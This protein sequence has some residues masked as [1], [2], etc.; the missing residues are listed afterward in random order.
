MK[1][2]WSTKKYRS[3]AGRWGRLILQRLILKPAVLTVV[4]LEIKGRH[5]LGKINQQKPLIVVA[6]HSSHFDAPLVISALPAQ[7]A[8]RLATAAAADYFFQNFI[9]A[10]LTRLFFNA[11]PVSRDHSGRYHGLANQLLVDGTPLLIFPEGTRTRTGQIGKFKIGTAALAI[12]HQA[13]ILPITIDGAFTAWPAGKKCWRRGR[14]FIRLTFNRPIATE[15]NQSAE[16]L[17]S[18]VQD[19][20]AKKLAK[21]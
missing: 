12:K 14:P 16:A 9:V 2:R 6:N 10:W 5:N 18:S 21:N 15:F 1:K 17:S 4:R 13:T 3:L 7:A 8:C 20:I 11:F 19:I